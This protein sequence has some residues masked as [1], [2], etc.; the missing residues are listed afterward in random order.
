MVEREVISRFAA[1][2]DPRKEFDATFENSRNYTFHLKQSIDAY[3]QG[4][5]HR[6]KDYDEKVLR[7][8][9]VFEKEF[10]DVLEYAAKE[11]KRLINQKQATFR[12]LLNLYA[13]IVQMMRMTIKYI[14][15]N[16]SGEDGSPEYEYCEYS[17]TTDSSNPHKLTSP[18]NFLILILDSGSD[19]LNDYFSAI[20]DDKDK[21][22]VDKFYEK[23]ISIGNDIMFLN[24][25]LGT[26][27][28]HQEIVEKFAESVRNQ[29]Y[30]AQRLDSKTQ[31]M[32]EAEDALH[33][34]EK[35][36]AKANQ[37]LEDIRFSNTEEEDILHNELSA[38]HEELKKAQEIFGDAQQEYRKTKEYTEKI[39]REESPQEEAT[40]RL[41]TL[42]YWDAN[43]TNELDIEH[44]RQFI[45]GFYGIEL[46]PDY[47]DN[48]EYI[49][50]LMKKLEGGDWVVGR[51]IELVFTLVKPSD[52]LG[53]KVM[54]A[55]TKTADVPF[56]SPQFVDAIR[57]HFR[58][59]HDAIEDAAG[60]KLKET[61]Y[62]HLCRNFMKEE[63]CPYG[64]SCRFVHPTHS[65]HI[66]ERLNSY[67]D[68]LLRA[69]S[70]MTSSKTKQKIVKDFYTDLDEVISKAAELFV[71]ES[72]KGYGR[73]LSR[74]YTELLSKNCSD[75]DIL[76]KL[77]LDFSKYFYTKGLDFQ[78]DLQQELNPEDM[79]YDLEYLVDGEYS[80]QLT[81]FAWSIETA[82]KRVFNR[83]LPAIKIDIFIGSN[84]VETSNTPN[85]FD[86]ILQTQ[87]EK[88]P[89]S[90]GEQS[91]QRHTEESLIN[92]FTKTYWKL[93]SESVISSMHYIR[94]NFDSYHS[95][96]QYIKDNVP[97][98]ISMLDYKFE[99]VVTDNVETLFFTGSDIPTKTQK[100]IEGSLSASH[101][102]SKY[103]ISN[104][105]AIIKQS[106]PAEESRRDLIEKLAPRTL[107][108]Q[109]KMMAAPEFVPSPAPQPRTA[110]HPHS[111]SVR[112][113]RALEPHSP[114]QASHEPRPLFSSGRTS[115]PG[116]QVPAPRTPLF[117]TG[118]PQFSGRQARSP[119]RTAQSYYPRSTPYQSRQAS[120]AKP[121]ARTGF[122][123]AQQAQP[124]RPYP[125][126]GPPQAQQSRAPQPR[127]GTDPSRVRS[128]AN[129][130]AR[131][132]P[133]DAPQLTRQQSRSRKPRAQSNP[134]DD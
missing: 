111:S 15:E 9:N 118:Q 71:V 107:I 21:E 60:L 127:A 57:F 121:H 32:S 77:S 125:R 108:E 1:S 123:Q 62:D 81:S 114:Q 26:Y 23:L 100:A 65:S 84:T 30:G 97:V 90:S 122:S 106:L 2:Y 50:T 87:L 68:N 59:A 72:K 88:L 35:E 117:S 45:G 89:D 74:K 47:M 101:R 134:E 67:V 94:E 16:Y 112:V 105:D 78:N 56:G 75:S 44:A 119:P 116:S 37:K 46:G 24:S 10:T 31:D 25:R 86:D 36:I 98:C 76:S 38:L 85:V 29:T 73:S 69:S 58:H 64:D 113:A 54:D 131:A 102:M 14:H 42:N 11:A 4:L 129:P 34:I 5:K 8:I 91:Q 39:L 51:F 104:S 99:T 70:R 82:V 110:W 93:A 17:D 83:Y 48:P 120:A 130:H 33:E 7:E 13:P 133:R 92:E 55:C 80:S 61:E 66:T 27:L 95:Y 3:T 115:F 12:K 63:G 28:R 128:I 53:I 126:A 22:T 20:Y 6:S 109:E 40:R 49:E 79:N 19:T 96:M 43:E 18:E 103:I 52:R 124:A 41:Y 132:A